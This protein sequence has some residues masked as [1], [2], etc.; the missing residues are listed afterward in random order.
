MTNLSR[1]RN[2]TSLLHLEHALLCNVFLSLL[3]EGNCHSFRDDVLDKWLAAKARRLNAVYTIPKYERDLW[4]VKDQAF[5]DMAIKSDL[6]ATLSMSNQIQKKVERA[7]HELEGKYPAVVVDFVI[8][9]SVRRPHLR[10]TD[11]AHHLADASQERNAYPA[12]VVR[13]ILDAGEEDEDDDDEDEDE[14]TESSGGESCSGDAQSDD[15]DKV[16]AWLE[17]HK[18]QRQVAR[19][20]VRNCDLC[21]DFN[22]IAVCRTKQFNKRLFTADVARLLQKRRSTG[23]EPKAKKPRGKR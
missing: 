23:S 12:S 9:R 19:K 13:A 21:A 10:P 3:P 11:I 18:K 8:R 16:R 20:T 2:R 14:D 5:A 22:K 17:K 4:S 7:L 1:V 6:P 15:E